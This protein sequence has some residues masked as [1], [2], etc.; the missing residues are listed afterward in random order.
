MDVADAEARPQLGPNVEAI[1]EACASL[2]ER[3][4]QVRLQFCSKAGGQLLPSPEAIKALAQFLSSIDFHSVPDL[5]ATTVSFVHGS[6]ACFTDAQ[7][8]AL[9]SASQSLQTLCISEHVY[10][11]TSPAPF[12]A[13]I[14]SIAALSNLTKL[15]LTM[16]GPARFWPIST[17]LKH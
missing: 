6:R 9:P 5:L 15:H 1:V 2:Q 7:V 13:Q 17:T 14:P 10:R 3:G 11:Q 16:C 12:Q 4:V 8:K